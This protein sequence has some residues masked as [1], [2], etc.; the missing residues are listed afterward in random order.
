MMKPRVN[1]QGHSRFSAAGHLIVSLM[2]SSLPFIHP[3][4]VVAR[5]TKV[6]VQTIG[7]G[8]CT[9]PP[10]NI[11]IKFL[12]PSQ[13]EVLQTFFPPLPSPLN[14]YTAHSTL[15]ESPLTKNLPNFVTYVFKILL[16]SSNW[17][18]IIPDWYLIANHV[19]FGELIQFLSHLYNA[20]NFNLVLRSHS[21]WGMRREA[22]GD[23]VAKLRR[24]QSTGCVDASDGDLR[25]SNGHHKRPWANGV[26]GSQ[27]D[28]LHSSDVPPPTCRLGLQTRGTSA[29]ARAPMSRCPM[30]NRIYRE[31]TRLYAE[32]E[33]PT[34]PDGV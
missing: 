10:F 27:S 29:Q 19:S 14:V 9:P 4:S 16:W 8:H 11:A 28:L 12:P 34:G 6:T 32:C 13:G 2:S 15:I 30:F 22:C 23:V 18:V 21:R 31:E 33:A 24:K 20:I 5:V 25:R 1:T 26:L 7:D 17:F 3:E